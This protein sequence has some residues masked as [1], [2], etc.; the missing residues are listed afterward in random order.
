VTHPAAVGARFEGTEG[1]VQ[2]GYGEGLV[3]EPASLA[4]SK[5]GPDD[6]QLYRSANQVQN[7]IDCVKSRKEPVAPVEVGHRSATVCH[8]GNIAIRLGKKDKVLK[9]DPARERFT[10]DD[11]ANQLLTRPLRGP[12][13]FA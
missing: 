13:K 3:T 5:I 4:T 2:V 1:V 8:L 11:D 7:F 6:I 12:W 9:W 10:N